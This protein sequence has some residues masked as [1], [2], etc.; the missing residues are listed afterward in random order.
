MIK[1]DTTSYDQMDEMMLQL[2]LE[3]LFEFFCPNFEN[4]E[5]F[6]AIL[7]IHQELIAKRITNYE[8]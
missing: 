4:A 7:E 6:N 5:K 8:K 3:Q 1:E 2:K